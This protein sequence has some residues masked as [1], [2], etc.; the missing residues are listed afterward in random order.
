M[1]MGFLW[2]AYRLWHIYGIPMGYLWDT[3]GMY[4][5]CMYRELV[6]ISVSVFLCDTYG[7]GWRPPIPI[8]NY[9]ILWGQPMGSMGIYVS[10]VWSLWDL[11]GSM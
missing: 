1:S 3:Y 5:I 11:Y 2:D 6:S 4:S 10:A 8:D 9:G 7:M